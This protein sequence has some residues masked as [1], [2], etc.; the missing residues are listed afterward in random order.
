MSLY[1]GLLGHR[2]LAAALHFSCTKV[3]PELLVQLKRRKERAAR[4]FRLL[5]GNRS[6]LGLVLVAPPAAHRNAAI[7]AFAASSSAL[8]HATAATSVVAAVA[9][10]AA[11]ASA[12]AAVNVVAATW[13]GIYGCTLTNPVFLLAADPATSTRDSRS[14][15]A[16][17]AAAG[18]VASAWRLLPCGLQQ[19]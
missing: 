15:P 7:T 11:L 13:E 1:G 17:A 19:P 9:I 12:A 6:Q 5:G 3:L 14:V 8:A 10:A 2:R 4:G 16:A 18:V